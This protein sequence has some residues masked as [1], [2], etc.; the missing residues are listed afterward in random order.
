SKRNTVEWSLQ[1]AQKKFYIIA[2][3]NPIRFLTLL[4]LYHALFTL[5]HCSFFPYAMFNAYKAS[6]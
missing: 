3:T 5:F 2:N 4:P 1:M 6:G